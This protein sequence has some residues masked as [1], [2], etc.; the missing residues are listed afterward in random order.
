M[1][2][3]KLKIAPPRP[4]VVN[5]SRSCQQLLEGKIIKKCDGTPMLEFDE[6]GHVINQ[7]KKRTCRGKKKEDGKKEESTTLEYLAN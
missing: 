7:E 2:D 5:S 3:A 6:Q 4:I 1:S